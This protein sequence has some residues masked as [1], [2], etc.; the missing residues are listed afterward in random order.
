MD[1]GST[2]ILTSPKIE[3]K[4]GTLE[5]RRGSSERTESWGAIVSN[6]LSNAGLR[7]LPILCAGT[8]KLKA[9]IETA[10][11]ELVAARG[12]HGGRVRQFAV[13]D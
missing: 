10:L 5:F 9:E 12:G 13:V 4:R 6:F 3:E 1:G 11:W 7:S 2:K 8:G